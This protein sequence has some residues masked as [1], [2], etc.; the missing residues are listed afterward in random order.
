MMGNLEVLKKQ[1]I[2]GTNILAVKQQMLNPDRIFKSIDKYSYGDI[3]PDEW[4]PME[5]FLLLTEQIK[6][7]SGDAVLRKIGKGVVPAMVDA[8][9][10][11]AMPPE[12]FLNA[13]PNVYDEGNKGP[14][15]GQWKKISEKEKNIVYENTTMHDCIFE[16]GVLLGAMDKLGA[17]FPKVK[18]T[19]CK[20]KGDSA[21]TFNITWK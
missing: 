4:Y 19:K 17:K 18:Q 15:L 11:P 2:R 8:G 10:I 13:L 21:C 3:K 14:E 9:I 7:N 5:Q 20:S 12:A 16:E 6:S 1:K